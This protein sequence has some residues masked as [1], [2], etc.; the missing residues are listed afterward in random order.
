VVAV[1]F[2]I[3]TISSRRQQRA[4]HRWFN[5][6]AAFAYVA[7]GVGLWLRAAWAALAIGF[8]GRQQHHGRA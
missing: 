2:G 5:I 4:V 3:A 1:L 7:A 8:D 6:L